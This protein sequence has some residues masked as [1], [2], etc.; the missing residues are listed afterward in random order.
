MLSSFSRSP[1]DG[2]VETFGTLNTVAQA[3][4]KINIRPIHTLLPSKLPLTWSS[5]LKS[6]SED[7]SR[8]ITKQHKLYD[9]SFNPSPPTD[10]ARDRNK[11]STAAGMLDLLPRTSGRGPSAE[12]ILLKNLLPGTSCQGSPAKDPPTEDPIL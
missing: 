11:F 12:D 5:E 6:A 8:K 1:H 10:V 2:P 7:S 9:K 3:F 4:S